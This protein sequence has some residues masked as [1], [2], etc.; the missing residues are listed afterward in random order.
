[1]AVGS[2]TG[3][4]RRQDAPELWDLTTVTFV[5]DTQYVLDTEHLLDGRVALS[6]VPKERALDIDDE[7][8]LFVADLVR[9][10]LDR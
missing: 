1:V 2:S 6:P 10:E 8:D 3:I 5:A 9:K 7:F 4:V